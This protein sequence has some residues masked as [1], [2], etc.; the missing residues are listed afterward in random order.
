MNRLQVRE[1][2]RKTLHDDYVE[3]GVYRPL[4]EVVPRVAK[5]VRVPT[6]V[7]RESSPTIS[8]LH[9]AAFVDGSV[10]VDEEVMICEAIQW[11]NSVL[12]ELLAAVRGISEQPYL[13][14]LESALVARL[15][16][17]CPAPPNTPSTKSMEASNRDIASLSKTETPVVFA[18]ESRRSTPWIPILASMALAASL[19]LVLWLGW[20]R[21]ENSNLAGSQT[22]P[23]L[24]GKELADDSIAPKLDDTK[25]KSSG[26]PEGTQPGSTKAGSLAND[27]EIERNPDEPSV[28]D[29]PINPMP[30]RM[31]L[32]DTEPKTTDETPISDVPI[33]DSESIGHVDRKVDVR[34]TK[35]H[36]LLARQIDR[37][38]PLVSGESEIW[39][40]VES[41]SSVWTAATDVASQRFRTLSGS[42]AEGN[43]R[44][45]GRIILGSDTSFRWTRDPNN[46]RDVIDLEQGALALVDQKEGSRVL[47][48]SNGIPIT[49]LDWDDSATVV[50]ES[51][52]AGLQILIDDGTVRI[53]QQPKKNAL[54]LYDRDR[55]VNDVPKPA[56]LPAWVGRPSETSLLPKAVL[57]QLSK[58]QDIEDTLRGILEN[59]QSPSLGLDEASM[60]QLFAWRSTLLEED[61]MELL[62]S[63]RPVLRVVGFQRLLQ[64]PL[65]DPR[66]IETWE[67]VDREVQNRARSRALRDAIDLAR[68][69]A[70]I[71]AEQAGLLATM[72]E[73]RSVTE[74]VLADLLLRQFLG[75][76][77]VFDPV[78]VKAEGQRISG[79]WR[80][81][82]NAKFGLR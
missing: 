8:V 16:A 7:R 68:G 12:A 53:D 34:W 43:L 36:G 63:R 57:A 59:P 29:I 22:E 74:R 5:A 78:D 35:I 3:Y 26:N 64:S 40:G 82:I 47:L 17:L 28:A 51:G 61:W 38:K 54:L 77:P 9:I 19:L 2:I 60:G 21:R 69:G 41:G 62:K 55:I 50:I 31:A 56:R 33:S 71:S 30:E 75:G 49:Q 42:R 58:S 11:D 79:P 6:S 1:C 25:F 27:R 70:N 24:H 73:S 46:A 39:A 14:E 66:W 52:S 4:G 20:L 81:Y 67:K 10:S 18:T 13:P 15:T 72:L 32:N 37:A 65:W 76:G 80:R 45:G 48:Q 23:E 44:S